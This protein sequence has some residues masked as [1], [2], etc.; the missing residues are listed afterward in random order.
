M[1]T[2][3]EF[4]APTATSARR[5][6]MI[7]NRHMF[8][9]GTT[10]EQMAKV[11]V[12]QRQ[13]AEK[14]ARH[15]TTSP[16]R[17]PMFCLA[18]DRRPLTFSKSWPSQRR[19]CRYRGVTGGREAR[20]ASSRLILGAN[21]PITRHHLCALDRRVSDQTCGRECLQDGWSAPKDMNSSVLRLLHHHRHS[22]ARG[23]GLLQEGPGRTFR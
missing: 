2:Q 17:L 20:E 4:E 6:A 1:S 12:D 11:A 7:A 3:R 19:R 15:L 13:C 9:F 23:R 14:S 10:P 8:E 5:Y 16:S 21:T 22:H 18:D